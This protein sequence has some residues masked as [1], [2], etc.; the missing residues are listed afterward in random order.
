MGGSEVERVSTRS[1][2]DVN[3]MYIHDMQNTCL[4]MTCRCIGRDKR[5][6]VR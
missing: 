2:K 3:C 5:G 4:Y 1:T 6:G